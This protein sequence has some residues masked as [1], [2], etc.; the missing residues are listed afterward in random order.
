VGADSFSQ[1]AYP[2]QIANLVA[3]FST[4]A[5]APPASGHIPAEDYQLPCTAYSTGTTF[6]YMT[7]AYSAGWCGGGRIDQPVAKR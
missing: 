3:F 1:A 6:N 4:D 2:S 5:P 7:V